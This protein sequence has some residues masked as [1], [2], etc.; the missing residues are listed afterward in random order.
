MGFLSSALNAVKGGVLG[1]LGRAPAALGTG[2]A[3]GALDSF[4]AKK[5]KSDE[6]G[7]YQQMGL[8]PQE[9]MGGGGA[10]GGSGAGTVMGNQ[11]NTQIAME[12]QQ[13]YDAQQRDADRVNSQ[14]VA[15]ISSAPSMILAQNERAKLPIQ[16]AKLSHDA[17]MA[18]PDMQL[19]LKNM[20]QG[21]E[22]NFNMALQRKWGVDPNN[23]ASWDAATPE[24]RAGYMREVNAARS[25]LTGTVAAGETLGKQAL[26][27]LFPGPTP[28]ESAVRDNARANLGNKPGGAKNNTGAGSQPLRIGI[29]TPP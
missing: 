26:D 12:R 27:A 23:K 5:Q 10:S 3:A 9:I 19:F 22:N 16:L 29:P 28:A 7:L 25:P 15:S 17:A 20:S 4:F 24:Q 21:V 1:S 13:K 14:A 2:L 18:H 8:T 11:L 6:L